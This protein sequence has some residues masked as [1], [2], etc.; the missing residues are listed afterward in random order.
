[1]AEQVSQNVKTKI[2]RYTYDRLVAYANRHCDGNVSAAA[3]AILQD[4]ATLGTA[5]SELRDREINIRV[6]VSVLKTLDLLSA[7]Q[8]TY[9][10]LLRSAVE[11]HALRDAE[12]EACGT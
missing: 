10:S 1:M 12:R 7:G 11:Y 2:S 6:P 5:V 9:S 8:V 3:I 4:A